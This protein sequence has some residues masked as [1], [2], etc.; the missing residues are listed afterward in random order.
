MAGACAAAGAGP[1]AA[2][3]NGKEW[4]ARER[5]PTLLSCMTRSII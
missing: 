5:V 1:T 4:D 2:L 3:H